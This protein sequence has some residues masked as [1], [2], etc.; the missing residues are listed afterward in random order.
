[1]Y[2]GSINPSVDYSPA[3]GDVWLEVSL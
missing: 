3:V 1:L 2:V